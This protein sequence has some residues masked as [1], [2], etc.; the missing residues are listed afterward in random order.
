MG[1]SAGFIA[2]AASMASRDVNLV[3]IPEA[4]WR[5]SSVLRWLEERLARKGHAVIVVA[6]GAK[7]LEQKEAEQEAA[8]NGTAL[9][10]ARDASGNKK[11]DCVGRFLEAEIPKHFKGINQPVALKYIDPSYIIRASPAC[12]SDSNLCTNLAY[13][14]AHAAMAGYTGVTVGVVE[15]H[16]VLL[17]VPVLSKMPPR[18]VD[19]NGRVYARM[20][21]STGQPRLTDDPKVPPSAGGGGYSFRA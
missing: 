10:V 7:C 9:Q 1:R 16:Y 6:E 8:A 3:L 13:N 18:V 4:D 15:N 11:L 12:A 20:C 19:I 2:L 17:P 14:A 21:A 5:L